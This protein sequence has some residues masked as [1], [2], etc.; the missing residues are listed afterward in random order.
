MISWGTARL[1]WSLKW[2]TL[3]FDG[4]A[5]YQ[6]RLT[7]FN[8]HPRLTVLIICID[9]HI[10]MY[11]TQ[12]TGDI[13]KKGK[14]FGVRFAKLKVEYYCFFVFFLFLHSVIVQRFLFMGSSSYMQ[15][16]S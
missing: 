12:I 14:V 1:G 8:D 13:T 3:N 7:H 6:F 9:I 2:V 5:P 4:A 10:E 16:C 15:I 11:Y